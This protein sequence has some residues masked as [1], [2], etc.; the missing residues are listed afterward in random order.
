MIFL[1]VAGDCRSPWPPA[2][3]V[4]GIAGTSGA[5]IPAEGGG[6]SE[7]HPPEAV[8]AFSGR[9]AWARN[10]ETPLRLFLRTETGSAVVLLGAALAALVW[11]NLSVSSYAAG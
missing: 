5:A 1:P 10:L 11:I 3:C 9:T 8:R 7:E 2:A 4:A 6:V